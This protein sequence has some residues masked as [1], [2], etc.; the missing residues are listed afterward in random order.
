[1]YSVYIRGQI[2]VGLE[3]P[4]PPPR[5]SVEELGYV[6]GGN[7]LRR[8]VYFIIWYVGMICCY[9]GI[10]LICWCDMLVLCWYYI[11]MLLC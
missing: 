7:H 4:L 9:V 6:P 10:M 3:R 8:V 5:D 2:E 1:M 11:G